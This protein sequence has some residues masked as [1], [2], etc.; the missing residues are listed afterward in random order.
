MKASLILAVAAAMASPAYAP[1]PRLSHLG[2]PSRSD[3]GGWAQDPRHR[4]GKSSKKVAKARARA[5][6]AAK[7]RR[8]QRK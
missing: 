2:V 5:K 1:T 7:S 8:A 4:V 3:L 6:V